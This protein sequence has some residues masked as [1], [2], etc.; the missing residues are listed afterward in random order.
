MAGATE[1]PADAGGA[2]PVPPITKEQIAK[3]LADVDKELK[4]STKEKDRLAECFKDKEFM[5]MFHEYM[6]EIS[7]P[8]NRQEYNDYIRQCE[9]GG[10][11]A[12]KIPE[13]MQLILP[14]VGF[15]L[16]ITSVA[17]GKTFVNITHTEKLKEFQVAR[18]PGQGENWSMPFCLDNP[19]QE[20]DSEDKP[21]VVYTIAYNTKGFNDFALS[22]DPKRKDFLIAV[23]LEN[24][25]GSFK[26]KFERGDDEAALCPFV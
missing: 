26:D 15:C 9:A 4:M 12:N 24:I 8:Q 17:K 14:K 18:V 19:K 11:T 1:A 25:E 16:K 2:V 7:D 10:D 22:M 3:S 20:T 5:G 6:Q 21:V 23:A 13:G